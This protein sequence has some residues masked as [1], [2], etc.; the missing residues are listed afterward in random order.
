[1]RDTTT[2]TKLPSKKQKHL[3]LLPHF[4]TLQPTSTKRTFFTKNN[5]TKNIPLAHILYVHRA[6][7]VI[8]IKYHS[9]QRFRTYTLKFEDETEAKKW[10]EYVTKKRTEKVNLE[11]YLVERSGNKKR[12]IAE[13][14]NIAKE[15]NL[16]L[17]KQKV[18]FYYYWCSTPIPRAN[19]FLI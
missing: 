1:M 9:E 19:E 2:I 4:L 8:T 11:E 18:G 13:V 5:K 15:I 7:E 16:E 17:H 12:D 10:E 6:N 14:M 3:T